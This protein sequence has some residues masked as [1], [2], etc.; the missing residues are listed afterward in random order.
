MS[1]GR[2]DPILAFSSVTEPGRNPSDLVFP[3]FLRLEQQTLIPDN[4]ARFESFV[5]TRKQFVFGGEP[6]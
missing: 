4:V 2:A 3:Q 1:F 6:K 5:E